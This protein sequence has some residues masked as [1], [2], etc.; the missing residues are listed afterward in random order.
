MT[1]RPIVVAYL[2]FMGLATSVAMATPRNMSS[3]RYE[4]D[5]RSIAARASASLG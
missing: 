5:S 4:Y 3:I 1:R 2:I